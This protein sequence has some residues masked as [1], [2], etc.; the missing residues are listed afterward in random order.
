MKK[1]VFKCTTTV[2]TA[3]IVTGWQL[4]C[5]MVMH[6]SLYARG[7]VDGH[8]TVSDPVTGG[9]IASGWGLA[10]AL[11][12]YRQVVASYGAGYAEALA[13]ARQVHQGARAQGAAA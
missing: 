7:L 11:A 5:G 13:A 2:G 6:R 10:Q 8:W 4:R 3:A 9:R 1:T 12:G